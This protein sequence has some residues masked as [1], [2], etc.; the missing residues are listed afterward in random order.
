MRFDRDLLIF[1]ALCA[2]SEVA[3]ASHDAP[4][5]PTFA[6]RF[7]LAF[8]YSQTNGDSTAFTNFWNEI[9]QTHDKAYHARQ[10]EYLRASY[11]RTC[12][13]GI[14][15]AVKWTCPGVPHQLITE[16][17]STGNANKVFRDARESEAKRVAEWEAQDRAR[18]EMQ[19]KSKDCGYL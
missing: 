16:A 11:S 4:I 17:R 15:N 12:V 14:I 18:R 10:G 2:L 5:K 9:Q 13:N 8:L 6:I 7:A 1:K 19:R 3:D